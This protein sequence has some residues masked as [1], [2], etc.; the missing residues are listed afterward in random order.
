MLFHNG[1]FGHEDNKRLSDCCCNLYLMEAKQY[2][3]INFGVMKISL[4]WLR[5][6]I[7]LPFPPEEISALLTDIGL[8]VESIERFE[9]IKGG[10][11]GL[12]AGEIIS[13]DKHPDADKL[14]LTTVNIG[15]GAPLQ[16]ICG[17]PNVAA[18]QKVVVA[19]IGTTIYPLIGEPFT[20]SRVKIR[21]KESEGMLCAEDEIG[22]G[23]SHAGIIQL[24]ELTRPGQAVAELFGIYADTV[25]E[26]GLTPN[27]SDAYSHIGVARDLRAAIVV[28][29]M[30]TAE[31]TYPDVTGF[32][33]GSGA[34]VQ[35]EVQDNVACPRYAGLTITGITIGPSPDWLQNRLRAIGVRPISNI[36]D[37]TNYIQHTYGQPLHAFDL[38]AV[39]GNAIIV[40]TLPTG[41]KFLTLDGVE[42]NL[43]ADDLMICNAREGMCMAGVYGGI[44]S[45]VQDKTTSI[46]L[47]SAFF[48]PANIRQSSLRHG[49]RTDAAQHFEKGIDPNITTEALKKAAMMI[50]EIAGG[51]VS[52]PLYDIYPVPVPHRRVFLSFEKVRQLTGAEISNEEILQILELLEIGVLSDDNHL[53]E[54]EIP[55]YRTDVVRDVDVI[56]DLLRI[57]GYNK[58][59]LT[60]KISF[61]LPEKK[62]NNSATLRDATA[63]LLSGNGAFEMMT[64][65]LTRSKYFDGISWMQNISPVKLL[66][67]INTEL[68]SMRPHMFWT[69]L[70]SV[71]L[72]I[73]HKNSG[74]LL[75]E[76]GKTYSRSS[77]SLQEEE[78]LVIYSTG[79]RTQQNWHSAAGKGD[80]FH[81][82]SLVEI[83]LS[84]WGMGNTDQSVSALPWLAYGLDY[85]YRKKP[86]VTVGCLT[87]D[88]CKRF[89][90]KQE[91]SYAEFHWE[92]IVKAAALK[93]VSYQEISKYPVVRRDLALLIDREVRFSELEA[94]AKKHGG[95]SL[96]H[97]GL[98]DV[99]EGEKIGKDKKS[100]AISLTFRNEERTMTDTEI[101]TIMNKLI[102]IYQQEK[103]AILR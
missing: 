46:F 3:C 29:D 16:I 65:P 20:I 19:T 97:V 43:N 56:E 63:T 54:L 21:G 17:A 42:R 6:Y 66:S 96:Q 45:G 44:H 8:E 81:L 92:N 78:M 41:T 100:Y 80:F 53:L 85:H 91:V 34:E 48:N 39:T 27:R 5:E 58:V 102:S 71:S 47:E 32:R 90:I 28:R 1:Y 73:N 9:S 79:T 68:D 24:P 101:D 4:N 93:S 26:I 87:A 99:Y 49:L 89:D 50:A 55:P 38:A 7:R 11:E 70:E 37:I 94:L 74:I 84:K 76:F 31:L 18:G 33:D 88:I 62:A 12:I 61:S 75:Y 23:E 83:L 57:Y 36:V 103:G 51:K 40:K 95:T 82:K 60:A 22:L 69:G 86:I 72:N 67:S 77:E 98:F 52:S 10:L 59:P 14:S 13:C 30:G 2:I 35:V 64:N 25:F 15:S